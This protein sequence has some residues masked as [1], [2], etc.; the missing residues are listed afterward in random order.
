MENLMTLALTGIECI[1]NRQTNI[2]LYICRA[3]VT[4][5]A[6]VITSTDDV[7]EVITSTIILTEVITSSMCIVEV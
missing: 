2:L 5:C 3:E 7:V 6:E 4:L 1:K